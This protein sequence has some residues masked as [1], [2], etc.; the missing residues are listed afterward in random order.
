VLLAVGDSGTG[1]GV[2]E[3]DT[4][5]SRLQELCRQ[6]C[7]NDLLVINGGVPSYTSAQVLVRRPGDS[8]CSATRACTAH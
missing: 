4:Y 3:E 1:W 7:S 2:D 5:P 8:S 6:Y